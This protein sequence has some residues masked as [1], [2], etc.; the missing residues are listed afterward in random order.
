MAEGA[1]VAVDENQTAA[2]EQEV[3]A[4]YENDHCL[5]TQKLSHI[6]FRF[7]TIF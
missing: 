6:D 4:S 7:E 5:V 1:T 2:N 3:S